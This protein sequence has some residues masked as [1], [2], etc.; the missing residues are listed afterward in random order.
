MSRKYI[1]D[2][3]VGENILLKGWVFEIRELAKLKF[4]I[5]R[6]MTGMVQCIIKNE[7]LFEKITNLSLESV[8]EIKGKI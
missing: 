6:D 4:L 1:D 5:L 8:I 3:K 2:L 7:E